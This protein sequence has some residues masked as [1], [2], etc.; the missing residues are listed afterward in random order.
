M[1]KEEK[2]ILNNSSDSNFEEII[3]ATSKL[4]VPPSKLGKEATWDILMQS[5]DTKDK[6]ETK[7][8]S[9]SSRTTWLSVAASLIVLFTISTLVYK[10][11]LVQ[12]ES[13]KGTFANVL[14][15]DSSEVKLNADSKIEYRKYGWVKNREIKLT[16]EA[17]FSVKK[18]ERFTVITDFDRK[19]VVTG[20]KFNV[21]ARG[22][23]FEVKC[24]EGSVNVE[25]S[26]INR[27]ALVKGKGISIRNIKELPLTLELDSI[28]SPK[29][30]IGEFY[31]NDRSLN[32]VFEELSRQFNIKVSISEGIAPESRKYTGYFK[33][34]SLKQALNLVCLP[35]GLT[36]QISSDSTSVKINK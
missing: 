8:V 25:T 21:F 30:I 23:Q 13:L 16:G 6:K 35:M 3:K 22:E 10:Y 4:K 18:G 28:E 36:Y 15:P 19:I 2:N 32:L 11:S 7:T 24:F 14:L 29:W 33:K 31:F 17:F 12:V 5:I 34:N 1:S 20:T 9:I 26:K 27:V